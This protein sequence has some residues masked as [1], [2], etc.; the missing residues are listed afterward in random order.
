MKRERAQGMTTPETHSIIEMVQHLIAARLT[1]HDLMAQ[2]VRALGEAFDFI[3]VGV[4]LLDP[5]QP[6]WLVLRAS[7]YPGL[8]DAVDRYRQP[9][10]DGVVGR[11][12]RSGRQV[13][14]PDVRQDPDYRPLPGAAVVAELATPIRVGGEVVGVL[15][16]ESLHPISPE[17]AAATATVATLLG[18]ALEAER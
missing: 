10:G 1:P 18:S 15:N 6:A 5:A 7:N 2:I 9:A 3:D 17:E 8:P 13:L 4:L 12:L 14:V 11:A 16:V